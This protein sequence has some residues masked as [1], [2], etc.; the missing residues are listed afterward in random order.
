MRVESLAEATEDG[1]GALFWVRVVPGA[2]SDRV[3]G[4]QSDGKLRVRISAPPERGRANKA[5]ARLLAR[6]LGVRASAFQVVSGETS[7]E[8]RLQ[9]KGVSP[10]QVRTLG[11]CSGES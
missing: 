5:L 1:Q 8:K 7:R 11:E 9:V 2:S 4:W 6:R 3:V 10:D